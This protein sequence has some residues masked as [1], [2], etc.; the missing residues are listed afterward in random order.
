MS[1]ANSDMHAYYAARAPHYDAVY[2][3]PE[4]RDDIFFLSAHLQDRFRDLEVIEIAC[5]TGYWSQHIAKTAKSLLVTDGTAEP[6]ELARQRLAMEAV[7]F[8]QADAY[9]LSP[10]L[11]MF[12]GCFAGLWFS[13]VPIER[14]VAFLGG[15]HAHL[16][17]GA[18][19]I[20]IDN[21][22]AQL[23]DF[24]LSE[25]DTLGNTFQLR[26]LKDGSVHRVLKNFPTESELIDLFSGCG[27][28]VKYTNLE[29][30]WML[31]YAV[32]PAA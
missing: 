13:H 2:R 24:P 8:L 20:F 6:L 7:D 3:K 28:Q 31:E 17:P 23:G 27:D 25:T 30:F 5:G 22:E 19:V 16:K 32:K 21:N 26:P 18:R 12:D 29:N 1:Q 15:L 9:A 4:R 14:R 11:G 10:D